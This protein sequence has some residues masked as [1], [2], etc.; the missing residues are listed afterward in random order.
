MN[1]GA[2]L[3]LGY[4]Y[5]VPIFVRSMPWVVRK[6]DETNATMWNLQGLWHG[7]VVC[8]VTG[9]MCTKLVRM[10]NRSGILWVTWVFTALK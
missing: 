4:Y 7:L 3:R 9:H 2:G 6:S 8:I 1:Y 10:W 5:K